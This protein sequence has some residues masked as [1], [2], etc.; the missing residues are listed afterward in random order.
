MKVACFTVYNYGFGRDHPNVWEH[1]VVN[2]HSLICAVMFAEM[3]ELLFLAE[4]SDVW[5]EL[6]TERRPIVSLQLSPL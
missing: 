2:G 3:G 1:I 4:Q 6:L 5:R